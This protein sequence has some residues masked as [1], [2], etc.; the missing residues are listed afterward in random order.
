MTPARPS[1]PLWIAQP[2]DLLL[3]RIRLPRTSLS[4]RYRTAASATFVV[5]ALRHRG[6]PLSGR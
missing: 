2:L 1:A 3:K 6:R 4:T 5:A